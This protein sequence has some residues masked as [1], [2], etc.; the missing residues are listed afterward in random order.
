MWRVD[1]CLSGEK[2]PWTAKLENLTIYTTHQSVKM[3]YL[4]KPTCLC[5]T[6]AVTT[7]YRC[8]QTEEL[9]DSLSLLGLCLHA[10]MHIVEMA[11]SKPQVFFTALLI[12]FDGFTFVIIT[13]I[14]YGCECLFSLILNRTSRSCWL[15]AVS[16]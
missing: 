5:A 15:F 8:L 10:D 16:L 4:L 13:Y 1:C 9:T 7:K 11:L 2:L 6:L 14:T 3:L 12:D